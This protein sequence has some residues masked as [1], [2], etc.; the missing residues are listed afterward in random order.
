MSHPPSRQQL[1]RTRDSGERTP[2]VTQRR[3]GSRNTGANVA[4]AP[5]WGR[6][7]STAPRTRAACAR[8]SAAF[9]TYQR[10]RRLG[11]VQRRSASPSTGANVASAHT[12]GRVARE[13]SARHVGPA[14]CPRHQQ[15][16]TRISVRGCLASCSVAAPRRVLALTSRRPTRGT[17]QTPRR[18]WPVRP[19]PGNQ[20]RFA[21]ISMRDCLG[22]RSVAAPRRARR[23]R[24]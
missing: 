18:H 13:S 10:G 23:M 19:V 21:R 6:A 15:R 16:F 20:Q 12:W 22:S 1:S 8:R 2:G 4:S 14:A 3:S 11:I 7:C 24:S 5:T 17:A 9:R